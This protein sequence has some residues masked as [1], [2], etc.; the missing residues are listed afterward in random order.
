MAQSYPLKNLPAPVRLLIRPMLL[1]SLGLHGLLLFLPMSSDKNPVLAKKEQAVKITQLPPSAKPAS[2]PAS[3][4]STKPRPS[5]RQAITVNRPRA[6]VAA[7]QPVETRQSNSAAKQAN[8]PV[9]VQ[10]TT[11]AGTNTPFADFPHYPGAKPGCFGKDSCRQAAAP[12]DQVASYF[13]KELP[14]KK[15]EIQPD[16]DEAERKVYQVSKAG[17]VQY[18]NLFANEGGAA[19][20]LSDK[21]LQLTDIKKAVE[22]PGELYTVL[23]ELGDESVDDTAFTDPTQFYSKLSSED[24]DGSI[25]AAEPNPA[26]DGSPK[27]VAGQTPDK[28]L[29]DLQ[30]KLQDNQ[31]EV[32]NSGTYG[33]GSLYQMTKGAFTGYLNLLPTKDRTG[34]IVVV[35][36][37]SPV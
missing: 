34:T 15:Y 23:G 7:R 18:L 1:I 10:P 25:L 6:I 3:Q 30:P 22:V 32:S 21:P 33:G 37:S 31:I 36:T 2:K 19:Y 16:A 20:V 13:T 4:P 28:V 17:T 12:L 24:T 9:A 29:S 14:A 26:I 8:R 11:T 5:T 27:L 35:W